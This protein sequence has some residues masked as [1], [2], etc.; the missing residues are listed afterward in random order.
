MD[1]S[2]IIFSGLPGTGK[3]TNT[4]QLAQ[5]LKIPLLAFYHLTD[6][7]IPRHVLTS[8][9]WNSDDAMSMV[10]SLAE[11]QLELGVSV[12]PDC[13]FSRRQSRERA[14]EQAEKSEAKFFTI[15]TYCFDDDAWSLRVQHRCDGALLDETLLPWA[16]VMKLW[17]SYE[18]WRDDR[19][20]VVDCIQRLGQKR[21]G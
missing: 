9:D 6:Q 7:A 18:S 20:L 4:R 5:R 1:L 12:I 19:V 17:G 8:P 3:S 21:N 2:L 10:F 11:D 15:Y 16:D 14:R 13:V